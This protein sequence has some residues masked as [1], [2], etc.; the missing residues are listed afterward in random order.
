MTITY[1]QWVP[2]KGLSHDERMARVEA[3]CHHDYYGEL[4]EVD[5]PGDCLTA[6]R[7][8][9][10]VAAPEAPAGLRPS[11]DDRLSQGERS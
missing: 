7:S 11:G 1:V 4:V 10:G 8:T 2:H 5:Y 3:G 9:R 6:P